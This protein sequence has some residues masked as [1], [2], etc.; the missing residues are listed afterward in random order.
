[1]K[2]ILLTIF[3]FVIISFAVLIG[4]DRYNYYHQKG[5]ELKFISNYENG[6]LDKSIYDLYTFNL[7]PRGQLYEYKHSYYIKDSLHIFITYLDSTHTCFAPDSLLCKLNRKIDIKYSANSLDS[8]IFPKNMYLYNKYGL[9]NYRND[10]QNVRLQFKYDDIY[11]CGNH[12]DV[13]GYYIKNKH[14][15]NNWYLHNN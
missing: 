4:T 3:G 12:P 7:M 8:T 13:K 15:K 9:I 14:I 1:M 10:K 5:L 6:I 2:S 11:W